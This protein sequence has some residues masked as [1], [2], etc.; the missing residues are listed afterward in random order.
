MIQCPC[1]FS[2]VN[3]VTVICPNCQT[4]FV[5]P[6]EP[7]PPSPNAIPALGL[8]VRGMIA[9][10]FGLFFTSIAALQ[11]PGVL[12]I[13]EDASVYISRMVFVSIFAMLAWICGGI[14][15]HHARRCKAVGNRTRMGKNSH[16]FGLISVI[17][18]SVS[19]GVLITGLIVYASCS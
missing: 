7:P 4:P 2:W 11:S 5:T 18:A 15:L 12:Y 3:D 13:S 9:G 19:I 1:C 16:L 8:S 6:K 14:A 10:I 17:T